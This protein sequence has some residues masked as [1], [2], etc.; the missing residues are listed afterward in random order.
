MVLIRYLQVAVQVVVFVLTIVTAVRAFRYSAE[1]YRAARQPPWIRVLLVVATP[2]ALICPVVVVVPLYFWIGVRPAMTRAGR[3]V[4][5]AQPSDEEWVRQARQRYADEIEARPGAPET[6]A[7][8]GRE[9]LREDDPFAAL[10][11]FEEAI[12]RLHDGYVTQWMADRQPAIED[13]YILTDYLTALA[14]VRERRP[15]VP[16]AGTVHGVAGWLRAIMA[17]GA[18][19]DHD[20]TPY[21]SAIQRLVPAR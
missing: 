21:L 18:A 5:A 4:A 8:A 12:R 10:L 11:F 15:A 2:F 13:S 17:A 20:V 14:K 6:A 19:A 9:R 7:A 1:E 3:Q 16:V